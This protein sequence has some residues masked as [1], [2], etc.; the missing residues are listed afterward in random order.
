MNTRTAKTI[1]GASAKHENHA[2]VEVFTDTTIEPVVASQMGD[3]T[4][5]EREEAF[6]NE[7]V[8]I[9]IAPTTDENSP[10]HVL[11]SVNG[12]NMPLM[13]GTPIKLK[14]KYVEVL[15]RCNETK[16][17]QPTRDMSNPEVGNQL[18][19]NTALTYPFHV[20]EDTPRGRA[21]LKAVR[22]EVN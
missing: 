18:M 8:E 22:S 15:A 19:G 7:I 11:I 5:A 4:P 3:F 9:E 17:K 10:T 12:V 16:Y 20:N 13:R 14:R 21:W 1:I 6:M 2:P